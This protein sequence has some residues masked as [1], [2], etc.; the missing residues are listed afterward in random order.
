MCQN[1]MDIE[2]VD[3][4]NTPLTLKSF[5][6]IP[7]STKMSNKKATKEVTENSTVFRDVRGAKCFDKTR[8]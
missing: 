7:I 2:E 1:G 6:W 4:Y 8:K 3:S 5:A